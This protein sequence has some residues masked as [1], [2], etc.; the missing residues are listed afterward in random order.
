LSNFDITVLKTNIFASPSC[1]CSFDFI[2]FS[3][4]IFFPDEKFFINDFIFLSIEQ[5]RQKRPAR[6]VNRGQIID[7]SWKIERKSAKSSKRTFA[8]CMHYLRGS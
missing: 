8:Y 4:V 7:L 3:K 1:C 6:T 5:K 2:V